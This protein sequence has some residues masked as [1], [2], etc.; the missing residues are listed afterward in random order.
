MFSSIND[1]HPLIVEKLFL[2]TILK[3]EEKL[4]DFKINHRIQ[5]DENKSNAE[6]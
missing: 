4:N 2:V 6:S 1:I 5:L 3:Y